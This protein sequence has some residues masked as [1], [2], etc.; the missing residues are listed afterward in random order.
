LAVENQR[1]FP[2]PQIFRL[3]VISNFRPNKIQRQT[4]P[5]KGLK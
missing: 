5:Q 2:L 4:F 3:F 1:K